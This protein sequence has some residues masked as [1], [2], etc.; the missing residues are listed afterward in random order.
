[1]LADGEVL[2]YLSPPAS[3]IQFDTTTLLLLLPQ[4]VSTTASQLLDGPHESD[5]ISASSTIS[6]TAGSTG[7]VGLL[8]LH[9]CLSRKVRSVTTHYNVRIPTEQFILFGSHLCHH[10]LKVE[11]V[12]LADWLFSSCHVE[13]FLLKNDTSSES[14]SNRHGL[15]GPDPS[16]RSFTR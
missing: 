15:Y 1:M 11:S 9:S 5:S 12:A 3:S 8:S 16:R 2:D 7:R 13:A 10:T 6:H 14:S 4:T